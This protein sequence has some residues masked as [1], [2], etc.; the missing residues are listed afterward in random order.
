M[1][2]KRKV[3]VENDVYRGF[4][5]RAF[6]AYGRRIGA[7]DIAALPELASLE[8]D[9]D[10]ALLDAVGQLIQEPHCYSWS[11]VA[12]QLGVTRQ[13]VQQKYGKRLEAQGIVPARKIGG[14]PSALR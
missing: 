6:K 9:L 3:K 8:K 7:G 12:A 10:A 14:Q 1:T 4:M 13:A 2:S 11:E 5:G